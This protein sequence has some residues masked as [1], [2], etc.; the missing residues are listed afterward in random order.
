MCGIF[1]CISRHGHR[2]IS[3]QTR[4]LLSRRGPDSLEEHRVV[5]ED[6]YFTFVSSVLSMR[7]SEV[8]SQPLIREESGSVL[9]WNG[10]AWKID[11]E[12]VTGNDSR[13]V[14]DL[15]LNSA[16]SPDSSVKDIPRAFSRIRGPFASIFYD[17]RSKR[18]YFGRDCLGRRSLV[19]TVCS[20]GD[21]IIASVSDPTLADNWIE[22]EGDGIYFLSLSDFAKESGMKLSIGLHPLYYLGDSEPETGGIVCV[23]KLWREKNN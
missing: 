8:V 20:N 21:L 23:A 7:G 12:P 2:Q 4:T 19:Q 11:D 3:D 13:R 16:S 9:C 5:V 17:G 14:F 22:V 1:C 18:L 6:V 15:L 10:E